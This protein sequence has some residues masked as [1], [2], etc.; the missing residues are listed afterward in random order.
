M[1]ELKY[2]Q[3]AGTAMDQVGKQDY[4]DRFEHYRGNTLV[5]GIN[6]DKD[7][8]EFKRHIC[9]IDQAS[10][11]GKEWSEEQITED[12]RNIELLQLVPDS[13][14]RFF[15]DKNYSTEQNARRLSDFINS[16]DYDLV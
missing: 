15:L 6:Y 5:V 3:S 4:L 2:N 7:A 16:Q 10:I 1:K 11:Y 12:D 8:M 9:I 13:L 14:F